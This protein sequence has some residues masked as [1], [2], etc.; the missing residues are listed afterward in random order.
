[1]RA[2]GETLTR[3]FHAS[4]HDVQAHDQLAIHQVLRE[5]AG[6]AADLD[7]PAAE[8][9]LRDLRLPGKIARRAPHKLLVKKRVFRCSRSLAVHRQAT[10][11]IACWLFML[12]LE[13]GESDTLPPCER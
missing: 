10:A 4:I 9:L 12:S 8:L 5:V 11:N 3:L 13:P 2:P 6:S 1:M 7:D